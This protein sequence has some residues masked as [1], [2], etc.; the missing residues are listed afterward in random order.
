MHRSLNSIL[1]TTEAI[2]I[3]F[4]PRRRKHVVLETLKALS[5]LGA[6]LS[7]TDLQEAARSCSIVRMEAGKPVP[8]SPFYLIIS[9]AIAIYREEFEMRQTLRHRHRLLLA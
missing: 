4:T 8:D 3:D 7:E 5:P 6:Y 9:G 1:N 2:G